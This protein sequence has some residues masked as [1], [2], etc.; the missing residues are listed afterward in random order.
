MRK[1]EAF[2]FTK[3]AACSFLA[4]TPLFVQTSYAAAYQLFTNIA[5][6]NP[7]TLNS[8][9]KVEITAGD[10]YLKGRLQFKGADG[11]FAGQATSSQWTTIPYGRA[12]VRVTPK[13]V[14]G[15]DI[16]SLELSNIK[17]PIDS[18]LRFASTASI[19]KGY[20]I[21]PRFSYQITPKLA[22]G[23]GLT[24]DRIYK[25]ELSVV[26]PPYELR[27]F[28]DD[29][30]YGFV[31]GISYVY[32]PATFIN[33]SYYS[34]LN[35]ETKGVSTWGPFATTNLMNIPLPAVFT[36]NLVRLLSPQWAVSGTAKYMQWGIVHNVVIQDSAL[37]GGTTLV[38]PQNYHDSWSGQIGAHYQL[39]DKWGFLGTVIY[40]S[41]AQPTAYRPV[42]LPTCSAW[43]VGLGPEYAINKSLSV[44][45]L[46]GHAFASPA[47]NTASNVGPLIGRMRINADMVDLSMSYHV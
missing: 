35:H 7:A 40:D 41:N 13:L 14:I 20:D 31:A 4:L 28:G 6:D 33:A 5:Y 8:I 47:I 37:G 15:V 21:S 11:P 39:N 46:Y 32:N 19:I 26:I 43:T 22:V 9:K 17:Y 24:A 16:T 18:I 25:A 42:G 23:A 12:A 27:N 30:R 10:T 45:L 1:A 29:W 2:V 36:L 34:Q 38:L 44:K 3:W